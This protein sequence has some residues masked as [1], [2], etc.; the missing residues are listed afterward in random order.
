MS[1]CVRIIVLALLSGLVA[2][3]LPS[4]TKEYITE[5][6]KHFKDSKGDDQLKYSK[7]LGEL[8]HA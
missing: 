8:L 6:I 2:A 1:N 4:R 7:W 3:G 5:I